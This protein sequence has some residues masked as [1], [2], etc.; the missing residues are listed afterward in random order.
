MICSSYGLWLFLNSC[1]ETIST[2]I[3]IFTT[4]RAVYSDFS[5]ISILSCFSKTKQKT[6]TNSILQM[7]VDEHWQHLLLWGWLVWIIF[8]YSHPHRKF[9]FAYRVIARS[10]MSL[11]PAEL[12]NILSLLLDFQSLPPNTMANSQH[13]LH[14]KNNYLLCK[15]EMNQSLQCKWHG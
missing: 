11:L 14:F 2:I 3:Y 13:C 9:W 8:L 4:T 1:S 15:R 5:T 6:K 10:A 7:G 12:I